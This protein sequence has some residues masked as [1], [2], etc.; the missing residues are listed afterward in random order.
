[1]SFCALFS[2]SSLSFLFRFSIRY[3]MYYKSEPRPRSVPAKMDRRA[4]IKV[5]SSLPLERTIQTQV[6][7]NTAWII[8]RPMLL[9][10]S[11]GSLRPVSAPYA[12]R[13]NQ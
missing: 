3:S 2:L 12:P 8:D 5:A 13:V 11:F 9:I 4:S 6:K 10:S 7:T 1:M